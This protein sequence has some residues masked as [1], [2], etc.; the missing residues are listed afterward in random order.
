[1]FQSFDSSLEELFMLSIVINFRQ[2]S[3]E[4]LSNAKNPEWAQ[5]APTI[6]AQL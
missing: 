5:I 6:L 3:E 1:M 2:K 4:F